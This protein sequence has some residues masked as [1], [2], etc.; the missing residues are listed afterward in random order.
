MIAADGT[1]ADA[2]RP[3]TDE[4]AQGDA[5]DEQHQPVLKAEPQ[6]TGSRA[7][8]CPAAVVDL[9]TAS[10]TTSFIA[11]PFRTPLAASSPDQRLSLAAPF[12]VA[13]SP[14]R[15]QGVA[16]ASDLS[17]ALTSLP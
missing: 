5:R 16:Q 7:S 6:R 12:S 9:G 3:Q 14:T 10:V 8:G 17:S 15:W 4:G 2:L 13:A 1:L 11:R